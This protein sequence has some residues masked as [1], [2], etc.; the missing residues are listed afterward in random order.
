MRPA[1]WTIAKLELELAVRDRGSVIWSLIAPIA[2]AW[3]FGSMFSG[4]GPPAPTRVA[5]DG[6]ANPPLVASVVA[7][8]LRAHG[9]VIDS[10]AAE[11]TI[12]VELPDS[13]L[14][15]LRAGA[16]ATARVH[17]GSASDLRAQSVGAWVRDALYRIAFRRAGI[18]AAARA[19]R[20]W[21]EAAGDAPL[22]LAVAT[23]GTAPRI[24]TGTEHTLPAMLVMFIMF[25]LTTF[26]LGM[27]V[28]DLRSGKTRRITMSPTRTRDIL[29]A[30]IVARI[31][32]AVLQVAIILGVGSLVL[33]VRLDVRAIPAAA[34]LAAYMFAAAALGMLMASFFRST[35]KANA[36]GVIASLVMAALGG[37]WWPLEL[38]PDTMRRIALVF[39]TGQAMDGLGELTALGA[40]APFPVANVV[41]LCAMGCIMM[42]IA[43]RRMRAQMTL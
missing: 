31:A 28:E 4:G 11:G 1:W 38:V 41:V 8:V 16:P 17:P 9:A 10:A 13:L 30:Q 3:I 21:T 29:L 42:P 36:I 24:P 40:S 34:L 39:P 22:A 18:E 5:V 33:G 25:Q 23:L 14:A 6:G 43:A 20:P 27:W 15:A 7:D 19:G 26:F 2:M 35:D 32:W 37:C 12:R